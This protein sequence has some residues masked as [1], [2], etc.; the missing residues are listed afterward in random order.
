MND[1]SQKNFEQNLLNNL[2]DLWIG[3]EIELRQS[4]GKLPKP[5]TIQAAQIIFPPG[6]KPFVRLNDEIRGVATAKLASSTD[7]RVNKGDPI[8]WN[9]VEGLEKFHL[10]ESELDWGHAT[11]IN[12]KG[13]WSI[14]FD[15]IYNKVIS[16][17]HI[18]AAREF[19]SA[20][21]LALESGLIRPVIDNLHS[22]SE[23]AAKAYLLGHPDKTIMTT[24]RHG[25]I[26]S[27]MNAQSRL[28]NVN[29]QHVDS[30]NTLHNLRPSARYLRGDLKIEAKDALRFVADVEDLVEGIESRLS[31]P[32]KL[33]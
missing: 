7:D 31:F 15:F 13:T 8:T 3:P 18:D 9:Q 21:K 28:G 22:A 29:P 33:D 26:S 2:F 4:Q 32:P 14:F 19:L 12:L 30:F 16:K 11:I 24:K 1:K 5:A 23:L 6:E 25:F 17:R 20:A 27:R 10:I